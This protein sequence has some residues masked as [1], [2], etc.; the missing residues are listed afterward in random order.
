MTAEERGEDPL[1]AGSKPT[2]G[3]PHSSPEMVSVLTQCTHG[4]T[5]RP[6]T[7]PLPA[8]FLLMRHPQVSSLCDMRH[9][10]LCVRVI[11]G[12]DPYIGCQA[13]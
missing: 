5:P 11:R 4:L 9:S 13:C 6:T 12:R 8:S 1:P 2:M 7:W 3:S 10:Q